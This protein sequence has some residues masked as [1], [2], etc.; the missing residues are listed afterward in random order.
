[1]KTLVLGMGNPI[2]CDDGAGIRVARAVQKRLTS[3]DVTVEESSLAGM[4]MLELLAG[5]DRVIIVDAIQGVGL[6]PGRVY[7]FGPEALTRTRHASSP[8]DINFATALELGKKLGMALPAEIIIFGV[9]VADVSTFSEQCTPE[10]ERAIP[11]CVK[12]VLREI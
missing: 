4:D 5:Y 11:R 8:H 6:K 12:R 10:V 2:L 1:M 7:R 3:P 9:Q